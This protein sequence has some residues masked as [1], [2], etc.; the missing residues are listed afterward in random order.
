MKNRIKKN[1]TRKKELEIQKTKGNVIF[2]K[3]MEEGDTA[4]GNKV[5]E[6]YQR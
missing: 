3:G 2:G 1:Q 5:G 4:R 6:E